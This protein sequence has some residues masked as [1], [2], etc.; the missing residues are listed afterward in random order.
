MLEEPP[1]IK[2]IGK[3][4]RIKK[5]KGWN[6]LERLS[7]NQ[8]A[9]LSFAFHK[10][11][12]FTNNQAERDLRPVKTKQKVSACFRKTVGANHY[13]RIQGFISTVRKQELNP[14]LQLKAVFQNQFAW[15]N[16]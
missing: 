7:K 3:K 10:D 13:A 15:K 4:G 12:P 11:L 16:C 2:T 1:P 9:V 6:L 8:D 14:F 5:S